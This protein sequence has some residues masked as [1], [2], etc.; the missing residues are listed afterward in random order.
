MNDSAQI[1]VMQKVI[2]YCAN[3]NILEFYD[4]SDSWGFFVVVIGAKI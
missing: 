1:K 2:F 4:L 3:N